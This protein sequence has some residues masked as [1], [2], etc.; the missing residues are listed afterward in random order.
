MRFPPGGDPAGDITIVNGFLRDGINYPRITQPIYFLAIMAPILQILPLITAIKFLIVFVPALIVFPSYFI[1]REFSIRREFSVLGSF[2]LGMSGAI[3]LMVTWNDAYNAFAIVL[4]LTFY[5]YLIRYIKNSKRV[6]LIISGVLFALVGGTHELTFLI[7]AISVPFPF[8]WE[9]LVTRKFSVIKKFLSFIGLSLVFFAPLIPIYIFNTMTL[10]NLSAASTVVHLNLWYIIKLAAYFGF[11][12]QGIFI[13]PNLITL[14]II[15]SGISFLSLFAR[16]GTSLLG[17][18]F[19]GVIIG[20]FAFAFINPANYT[21]G[22]YFLTIPEILS[23]FVFADYACN[24]LLKLIE[25]WLKGLYSPK[26][27]IRSNRISARNFILVFIIVMLLLV[28]FQYSQFSQNSLKSASLYYDEITP[29]GY[30]AS[31]WMKDNLPKNGTV[32]SDSMGLW[33]GAISGLNAITP[34]VL[35]AKIT[36]QSYD[37]A[38]ESDLLTTG[39]Y[40]IGSDNF[41]TTLNSPH[42]DS[43]LLYLYS[44][45]Q[46]Y[47]YVYVNESQSYATFFSNGSY[48]K[49]GLANSTFNIVSAFVSSQNSNSLFSYS[50]GNGKII[51]EMVAVGNNTLTFNW[52]STLPNF[53]SVNQ[54]YYLPENVPVNGIAANSSSALVSVILNGVNYSFQ[55]KANGQLSEHKVSGTD[56]ISFNETTTASLKVEASSIV[57]NGGYFT[58]NFYNISHNL[59]INYIFLNISTDK[60]LQNIVSSLE[61][62]EILNAR[63]VYEREGYVIYQ[64]KE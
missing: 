30:N 6:D 26:H 17:A 57:Q 63:L 41:V 24:E 51:Y 1:L 53:V 36:K 8:I 9:A 39:T 37:Q 33:S 38:L 3:S 19:I 13:G 27:E 32:F 12:V 48:L 47:P 46:W 2:F 11:G 58:N 49:L 20:G 4:M 44:Y 31:L 28:S 18:I 21:R 40:I 60:L 16:K 25:T 22:F 15:L 7:L 54:S 55:F 61:S 34:S 52:Y 42:F 10:S 5:V 35:S 23:I 29:G 50:W 64:L 56:V 43:P 45:G 14:L 62:K 59:G